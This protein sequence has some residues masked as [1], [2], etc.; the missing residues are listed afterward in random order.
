MAGGF[1]PLDAWSIPVTSYAAWIW[2]T[3]L[4]NKTSTNLLTYG[5]DAVC[6]R[7]GGSVEMPMEDLIDQLDGKIIMQIPRTGLCDLFRDI[8]PFF[9]SILGGA[10]CCD[11]SNC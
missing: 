4:F 3:K 2:E 6:L 7:D 5:V 9:T 1:L 11:D 10:S 8:A